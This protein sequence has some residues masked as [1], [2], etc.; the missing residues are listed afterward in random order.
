MGLAPMVGLVAD[1]EGIRGDGGGG[2]LE[3]VV[4]GVVAWDNSCVEIDDELAA[5]ELR[6]ELAQVL[7]GNYL[8][9]EFHNG[10]L[11]VQSQLLR[12]EDGEDVVEGG[13]TALGAGRDVH[14]VEIDEG[15]REVLDRRNPVAFGAEPGRVGVTVFEAEVLG[16]NTFG[17]SPATVADL[18]LD[19]D[20]AGGCLPGAIPCLL[21]GEGLGEREVR[22]DWALAALGWLLLLFRRESPEGGEEGIEEGVGGGHVRLLR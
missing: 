14:G 3:S 19:L 2:G 13:G 4:R 22:C 16:L 15:V 20:N 7:F 10:V 6:A 11:E 18:L 12:L 1:E 21:A 17:L 8:V 9:M 5:V